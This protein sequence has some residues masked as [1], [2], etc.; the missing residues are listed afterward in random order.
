MINS[1]TFNNI[2]LICLFLIRRTVF[3]YL[4]FT[5]VFMLTVNYESVLLSR[6]NQLKGIEEEVLDFLHLDAPWD[7]DMFYWGIKYYRKLIAMNDQVSYYYGNLAFCYYHLGEEERAMANYQKAVALE[8][9]YYANYWDLGWIFFKQ[10][11]YEEAGQYIKNSLMLTPFTITSYNYLVEKLR[12]NR[13]NELAKVVDILIAQAREDSKAAYRLLAKSYFYSG[14][15]VAMREFLS[16]ACKEHPEEAELPYLLAVANILTGQYP[17]A[18]DNLQATL[19]IDPRFPKAAQLER[20]LMAIPQKKDVSGL[21]SFLENV[22]DYI[23]PERNPYRLH[24]Y[25]E[26]KWVSNE[27]NTVVIPALK[28]D[29]KIP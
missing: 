3:L 1:P 11:R 22:K 2:K 12:Q 26:L 19:K 23:P 29:E 5:V 24:F 8:H 17:P 10:G 28:R 15:F 16:V 14:R 27:L 21:K 18:F 7:E 6:V 20:M 13:R 9:N 4:V 25:Y